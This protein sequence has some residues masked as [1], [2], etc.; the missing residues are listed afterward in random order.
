MISKKEKRKNKRKK[1]NMKKEKSRHQKE[2][3]KSGVLWKVNKK[4]KISKDNTKPR[5]QVQEKEM[6][7]DYHLI[8]SLQNMSNL[9]LEINLENK[10]NN[11]KYNINIYSILINI[12]LVKI[13]LQNMCSFKKN[14]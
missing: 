1:C 9:M 4:K 6:P 7:M 2:N 14:S 11:H 13:Y 5:F 10:M 3:R 12:F 8:H